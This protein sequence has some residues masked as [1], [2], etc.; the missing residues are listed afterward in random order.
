MISKKMQDALNKQL[1][2]ELFSSYLY[3][4]MAAHFESTNMRG[5]ANWMSKQ[6]QEEYEHAMKFYKYLINVG[7]KVNLDAIEKPKGKWT[8]AKQAFD[9][10]LSHE[11]KITKMINDLADLAVTE[12]DHA[13]NIFLHWFVTEQVEEVASVEDIVNK[14][15]LIGDNKSGL[16]MLDRELS[17]R[18]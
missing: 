13:T 5:F 15:E 18:Q 8:S 7:A 16:F 14:F 2:A 10:A 11:K 12:K 9:E 6:S 17:H 1:N 3:L 4:S